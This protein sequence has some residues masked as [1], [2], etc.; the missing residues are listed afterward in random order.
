M[1]ED[2]GKENDDIYMLWHLRLSEDETTKGITALE[3][4]ATNATEGKKT[5]N[6]KARNIYTGK[7]EN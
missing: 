1:S 2:D 4:T 6:R 7:L 3:L 5:L